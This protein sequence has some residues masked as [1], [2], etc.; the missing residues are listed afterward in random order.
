MP[1]TAAAPHMS[2]FISSIFSAG[3]M[4]IPPESKVMPL[5]TSA[6]C[7]FAFFGVYSITTKRGSR[8]LPRLTAMR[9]PIFI[10][11]MSRFV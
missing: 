1:I 9:P 4:E 8:S 10:F 5:P 11:S 7:F 6:T 3:L 2:N